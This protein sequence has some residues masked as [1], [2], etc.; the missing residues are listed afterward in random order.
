MSGDPKPGTPEWD[1]AIFE[2]QTAIL[3]WL[4]SL[5]HEVEDGPEAEGLPESQRPG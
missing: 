4:K 2:N 5:G 1:E 3:A